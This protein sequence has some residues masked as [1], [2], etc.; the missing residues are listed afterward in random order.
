MPRPPRQ[1]ERMTDVVDPNGGEKDHIALH[2]SSMRRFPDR[3]RRNHTMRS[4]ASIAGSIHGCSARPSQDPMATGSKQPSAYFS[5]VLRRIAQ[6][7]SHCSD[8]VYPAYMKVTSK[9]SR[10]PDEK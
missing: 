1:P 3:P 2:A 10:S 8:C 4:L 9:S 6:Q 7:R 5:A